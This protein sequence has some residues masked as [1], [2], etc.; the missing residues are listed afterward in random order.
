M[1]SFLRFLAGAFFSCAVASVAAESNEA[2]LCRQSAAFFSGAE[3]SGE[4][5]YAPDRRVEISHLALDVTPD[6]EKRTVRGEVTLTFKPIAKPLDELRLDGVDLDVAAVLST[7]KIKA[8]QNTGREIVVTFAEP[9]PPGRETKL[10][11]RYTAQPVQGLYFRVPSNGYR[12]EEM[13]LWSQGE[14]TEARHWF[15][16]Y[17]YPNAKFTSEII[18]RVPEGMTVLSNGRRVSSEKDPATG[19]LAVRWSQEK[20]HSNYLITLVAGYFDTLEDTHRDVPLR[21]YTTPADSKQAA[22]TFAETKPAMEFFEKETG[23]PFAWAQYGQVVVRDFTWG[24]MENTTLTTLTESTLHTPETEN[25]TT[26]ESLVAHELAHQWFGDLV[27]CKDWS[28]TWLNEGFATYYAMLLAGHRHGRDELLYQLHGTAQGILGDTSAPRPIVFRRYKE[29]VEQFD[30]RTYG[31]G[32]WVLQMLRSELGED[33]YRRCI[34]TYLERHKFQNV[35]TDD[36]RAVVEELS[37]RSFDEFFDQWLY[38]AHFPELEVNYSWDEKTRLAKVSVRQQQKTGDLVPVFRFP[39]TLRFKMK[40][41]AVVDHRVEVR[42]KDEDFYVPLK[43]A[44]EVVRIDPEL[45]LLAKITFKPAPAMLHA[46]LADASDAIGRVIAAE[47]LGEK[48]EDATIAKLKEALNGDA[49]YGVRIKAAASLLKIHSD[50]ALEALV[51]SVQQPDA[52]V[53]N[54]VVGDIAG[55]FH[56]RA[57][58]SLRQTLETEKNPAILATALRGLGPYHQ[59]AVRELLL[60][61]LQTKSFRNQIAVA[62]IEAMRTQDDAG[63]IAPLREV[64]SKDADAFSSRDFGR[65]LDA[66]ASLDRNEKPRDDVRDFLT[67][68]VNH[69]RERIQLGAMHALGVLEDPK[70]IPL[71]ET[72][73]NAAKETPQREEA[74]KAVAAVRAANRPNDN[75]K[76]LRQEFLDLQKA[77]REL[78]KEFED[79][80]KRVEAGEKKEPEKEPDEKSGS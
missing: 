54:A 56:P 22:L 19:L 43:Q 37:G 3:S 49:F 67:G 24:G 62:V 77:G 71:L 10:T 64:L 50:G 59:P 48:N 63:H 12:R 1:K 44:P 21:F 14:M 28:H 15:P 60:S 47:E 78:K 45:A 30:N 36:L 7:A 25:I 31:K 6:F 58:E 53:R 34:Q 13:H 61:R 66:L 8:H 46:Q 38:R 69:K 9:V 72:F 41:G 52:R 76:D 68:F 80:K 73:A 16:C 40:D 65:V 79:F 32:A 51:A 4:S 29:P 11:I 70:A 18:C 5:K 75:L 27:T 55:F 39:L 17:D 2:L 33:L 74:E 26:S 20:P 23:V 35:V 57:F 42:E